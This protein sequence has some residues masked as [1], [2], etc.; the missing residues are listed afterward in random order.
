MAVRPLVITTIGDL[1]VVTG[2]ISIDEAITVLGNTG[3]SED[4]VNTNLGKM[5]LD[6]EYVFMYSDVNVC[7]LTIDYKLLSCGASGDFT[8][9]IASVPLF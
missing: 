8:F 9:S 6:S 7:D 3:M 2:L 5:I 1:D 4:E